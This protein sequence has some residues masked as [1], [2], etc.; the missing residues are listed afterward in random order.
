MKKFQMSQESIFLSRTMRLQ[1]ARIAELEIKM[2]MQATV[3]NHYYFNNGS[4]FINTLSTQ[5]LNNTML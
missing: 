5:D 1:E 4:Q 3:V 2:A